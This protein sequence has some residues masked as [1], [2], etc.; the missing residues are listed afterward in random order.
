MNYKYFATISFLVISQLLLSQTETCPQNLNHPDNHIITQVIGT[1]TIYREYILKV[2]TSYQEDIP[3]A[4][5]FNLHGFG[6]CATDY[7]IAIGNFYNF[8][9]LANSENIIVA[10][11]QGAYRQEKEETY[12]EPGDTG[13][14]NIYENDVYFFDQL[15]LD[16][17][18]EYNIDKSMIYACGYSNGGMMAYSLA[19][20]RSQVFSAIGIM[21]G[22]MLEE[23]C[24]L[25]QPV[26]IIKFHGIE[27]GV[28]PYEGNFWFQSVEEVVDFW[29]DKNE[30][31]QSSKFSSE[32]NEG[33][34]N[35][36]TY[37]GGNSNCLSLYTIREENDKP[38]GHVWFS[39][40][41]EGSSPNEVM[42]NFF[43]D[44]CNSIS[45]N[46]NS[47]LDQVRIS[48]N[49]VVDKLEITHAQ[50]RDFSLHSMDGRLILTGTLDSYAASINLELLDSGMYIM[51]IG[52][53]AHRLV[54][55]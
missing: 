49:P 18:A 32:L 53:I 7:S 13:S 11:P 4:L 55:L 29:L 20:N 9:E 23:D 37:S 36:D 1:D 48:P 54:K 8:K 33:K 39:D 16:I 44:N 35:L 5:V 51:K 31:P 28:L 38:G 21:S 46:I 47:K 34:V 12:W 40:N 42:W 14:D 17:E 19:C 2:P 24:A 45:S 10:Y 3:T 50:N 26:P 27:D 30:I 15:I 43:Q 6:G 41:I 25:E 52:N 22:T